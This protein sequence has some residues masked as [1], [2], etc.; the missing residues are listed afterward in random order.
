[1]SGAVLAL[2]VSLSLPGDRWFGADKLKHFLVAAFV[3]SVSYSVAQAAGAGHRTGLLAASGITVGVSIGKELADRR[4]GTAFS[5]K[6]LVWDLAG[7]GAAT[8]VLDRVRR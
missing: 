5:G 2:A 1:M 3:Q 7:G 4:R 6:D 8:L